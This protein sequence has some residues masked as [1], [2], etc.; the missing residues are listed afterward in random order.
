MESEEHFEII[1]QNVPGAVELL[2]EHL[3][4]REPLRILLLLLGG[5]ARGGASALHGASAVA[6][7][8][9]QLAAAAQMRERL[10]LERQQ[11]SGALAALRADLG[12]LPPEDFEGLDPGLA[13]AQ[14]T[15]HFVCFPRLQRPRDAALAL[16]LSR[17]SAR[18]SVL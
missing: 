9:Q 4:V 1:C 10:V 16:V 2:L 13:P 5:G 11:Q 8:V 3:L 15:S 14:C 12:S 7:A 18:A 6:R 17:I